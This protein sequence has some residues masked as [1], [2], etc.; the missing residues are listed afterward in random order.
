MA[1]IVI[2]GVYATKTALDTAE[3]ASASNGDTYIVGPK[4]PYALYT[5]SSSKTAFE[6][7]DKVSNVVSDLSTD[8][9]IDDITVDPAVAKMYSV[10]WK[11][12]AKSYKLRHV[13]G[14]TLRSE[15]Y[16]LYGV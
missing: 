5:Y 8:V 9:T 10:T 13:T 4:I 7:G 16:E 2:M 3:K 14:R 1:N 6:K 11:N 12:G 15:L